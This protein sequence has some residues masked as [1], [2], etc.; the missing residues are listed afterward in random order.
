MK[1]NKLARLL[2]ILMLNSGCDQKSPRANLSQTN[3]SKPLDR[4]NADSGHSFS[5][6]DFRETTR[7]T[8]QNGFI[9]GESIDETKAKAEKGD[10]VAQLTLGLFHFTGNGV[11]QNSAEA[12][13]WIR[14]GVEQNADVARS[15]LA[16]SYL[17][18]GIHYFY[19]MGVSAD[20]AEGEKWFRKG[21]ELENAIAQMFL[22]DC[23][24]NGRGL[25]HD[26][27][28]AANWYSKAAAQGLAE[29]QFRLGRCWEN[30]EGRP[31]D[32]GEATKW[33]QKA[34]DQGHMEA[35]GALAALLYDGG[36]VDPIV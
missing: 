13:K 14:K 5:W 34:A 21:A 6:E 30:G 35:Q 16:L 32:F 29:S 10:A 18:L 31:K 26:T 3:A 36:A 2:L 4:T 20:F 23:Y 25:P 7:L 28:E 33:Y 9:V 12:A 27:G 19:G 24:F 11:P 1:A 15:T 22:G 8:N 17:I